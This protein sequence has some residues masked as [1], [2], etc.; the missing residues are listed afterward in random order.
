MHYRVVGQGDGKMKTA[1]LI[2]T[3]VAVHC[4][5]VGSVALLPGCGTAG[6]P[7][8]TV[9]VPDRF[10]MPPSGDAPLVTKPVALRPPKPIK[11]WPTQTT[12]YVVGKGEC[13]SRIADKFNMNVAEI[14]AL[15]GIKDPNQLRAGQELIL[16]GKVNVDAPPAPV[17]SPRK[18]VVSEGGTHVVGKGDSLSAIAVKYSTTVKAIKEQNGLKNDRILVDQK[19]IIP[20]APRTNVAKPPK[21]DKVLPIASRTPIAPVFREPVPAPP[22]QQTSVTTYTVREGQTVTDV[23]RMWAV[24]AADLR[25]VN[26]LSGNKLKAGRVLDIPVT[27][28]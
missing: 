6:T 9:G 16:P 1:W 7:T 22:R 26:E 28:E 19:L 23:A 14:S 24:S 4:V 21:P 2:G 8:T 3:V 13:L 20:G 17:V 27:S 25:R 11:E 10:V 18:K 5:A 12:R 15:N